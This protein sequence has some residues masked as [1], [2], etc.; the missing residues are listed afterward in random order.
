[1]DLYMRN[2]HDPHALHHALSQ[3]RTQLRHYLSTDPDRFIGKKQKALANSIPDTFPPIAILEDYIMPQTSEL[4]GH[5]PTFEWAKQPDIQDI[6]NKCEMHYEWGVKPLIIKRFRT[7]IWGGALMR[8]LRASVMEGDEKEKRRARNM[9]LM[10]TPRKG[11]RALDMA[12]GTPS[13]LVSRCLSR[14]E[15]HTPQFLGRADDDDEDLKPLCV[16]IHSQRTHASTDGLL[17]YRLEIAPAQFVEI[18]ELG[19]RGLRRE[20]SID[21]ANFGRRRALLDEDLDFGGD[22]D[23]EGGRGKKSK[24][25]PNPTDHMRIWVPACMLEMAEPKLVEEYEGNIA[26]KEQKR[27]DKERRAREKAEGIVSPKKSR[28]KKA[29]PTKSKASQVAADVFGPTDDVLMAT[30]SK[31]RHP[32]RRFVNGDSSDE[33]DVGPTPRPKGKAYANPDFLSFMTPTDG[34]GDDNGAISETDYLSSESITDQRRT[35]GKGNATQLPRLDLPPVPA[36]DF[37]KKKSTLL[38]ALESPT[39]VSTSRSNK[40]PAAARSKA[41][42]MKPSQSSSSASNA[43]QFLFTLPPDVQDLDADEDDGEMDL[44]PYSALMED[45][46]GSS[47][48]SSGSQPVFTAPTQPIRPTQNG[49]GKG[50]TKSKPSP[51]DEPMEDFSHLF[52]PLVSSPYQDMDISEPALQLSQSSMG[53][54][55][56][57]RHKFVSDDDEDEPND[58]HR[59]PVRKSPKKSKGH[60]SPRK[61]ID[62]DSSPES[63]RRGKSA[64]NVSSST[65]STTQSRR[66]TQ[67]TKQSNQPTQSSQ[68][69]ARSSS[70]L[71]TTSMPSSLKDLLDVPPSQATKKKNEE[72]NRRPAGKVDVV[73][74]DSSSDEGNVFV[75]K[76]AKTVSSSGAVRRQQQQGGQTRPKPRVRADI[77]IIDLD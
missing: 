69:M 26:T 46:S 12:V 7:V 9:A 21:V 4:H 44:N 6:A 64:T 24:A 38:S 8:V 13:K 20:D 29:S 1:M 23:E 68:S 18:V 50:K 45:N 53:G 51:G 17:E 35:K 52:S 16:K 70:S 75:S 71:G 61:T 49:K 42:T 40:P 10:Q 30:P 22:E 54:T 58:R 62:L 55:S 57:R 39:K 2:R 3:W 14:M 76:P 11:R 56:G 19:L 33:G 74:L 41:P 65:Q 5:I 43:R 32:P 47:R 36:I 15:L 59:V 28:A 34:N 37:S 27:L 77:S 67:S 31:P 63:V 66:P 25:P 72:K 48:A 73:D 60:I